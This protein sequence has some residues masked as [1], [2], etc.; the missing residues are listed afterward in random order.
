VEIHLQLFG[1][2]VL[3]YAPAAQAMEDLGFAGAWFSDHLVTPMTY[4]ATYPYDPSGRPNYEST[5][6]FPDLLALIAHVAALTRRLQFGTGVYILPLRNALAT[7]RAAGTTALLSHGRLILGV[8]AGWMAEEFA[9]VGARFPGRGAILE[10]SVEVMRRLW[11]GDPV[12]YQGRYLHFA[13]VRMAPAVTVRLPVVLG[14][15]TD[16]ALDRAARIADG[17]YAMPTTLEASVGYRDALELRR[18]QSGRADVPFRYYVRPSEPIGPHLLARYKQAGF[19]DV[20]LPA[21]AFTAIS[22]PGHSE[23]RSPEEWRAELARGIARLDLGS[24]LD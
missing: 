4:D 14:G 19:T 8:G 24:C 3:D 20:V 17:W 2:D 13:D 7:A 12:S 5:T 11:T 9:A 6:P 21:R 18:R 16:R 10:E 23:P 22:R 15:M 1:L